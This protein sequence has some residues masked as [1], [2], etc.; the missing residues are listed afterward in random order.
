VD[1][2]LEGDERAAASDWSGAVELYLAA[3][4]ESEL[5]EGELCVKIARCHHRL[6]A[7]GRA[8]SW[9]ARIPAVSDRFRTWQAGASL[10]ARVAADSPLAARRTARVW[11][12]GSYTT[13]QLSAMLPLGALPAGLALTVRE[14]GF[15]QYRQD[16]L[17]PASA[18]YRFDPD[19]VVLA[20]H[21]GAAEL[22]ELSSA[23]ADDIARE[24]ER[25]RS[26]WSLL[27]ERSR[28]RVVQHT[29]AVRPDPALG[30]LA[31][32]V[33]G[34]RQHMLQ[35]LNLRLGEAAQ[36]RVS[37]VDC[38]RLAGAFGKLRWFDDR[39]WARSR[40]AVALDAVPG[41]AR[42]TA[43]VIS[44][45]A[46]LSRKCL[47]LDLDNTLWG[48]IIGEDGMAGI[49]LGGDAVGEAFTAFQEFLLQ[50]KRKGVIL[51]VASK[52]NP[53]DAREVFER[54]PEMRLRLD[55][56]AVFLANW[57]DK[58]A[59][60]R[61]IAQTL[62]IGLD[63]LV[64]VDDNPAER[65]AVRQLL[66]DVDVVQLP[67]D[68]AGYVQ[69]LARYPWLETASLTDEDR[70]RTEQYQ[71]RARIADL[72]AQAAS[73]EEFLEGLEM[74][75]RIAP[76]DELRLPRIAQLVN[77]TN[78]FNLTTRRYSETELRRFSEDD[79]YVHLCLELRDRFADHGLVAVLIARQAGDA[80]DIDTFLMSC[81]VIGRTVEAAML[82][83]LC[84]EAVRR[85][86]DRLLGRYVPSPKNALTKDVY[87][88]L[89]FV[90]SGREGPA[91]VWTLDLRQNGAIAG[92]FVVEDTDE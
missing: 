78:Q 71:A 80:L 13:A 12:T 90:L 24:A 49:R 88:R 92:G 11:V 43:A 72:E 21:E 25:W 23:P 91:T 64:F 60:I 46:G 76:F 58:P 65:E 40:Q 69:A 68:P 37:L 28:A 51:A 4:A 85:G 14:G 74:R 30:N 83:R 18:L 17:D 66:P 8:V 31:A 26:L 10:L 79:R 20:V 62:N 48:G 45:A 89:G 7:R 1:L 82:D 84:R 50:L 29:F 77:K 33:P 6:G 16:V 38:D 81:R 9:L 63:A 53:A 57:E 36:G 52:N 2:V 73:M 34:C 87:E 19:Y 54:H 75:A 39:Y 32:S 5:P 3:A 42:Q 41:L 35:A 44:A 27:A 22:P 15:D 70:R 86:C 47:V 67:G 59:S 61:R 56:V 55:D